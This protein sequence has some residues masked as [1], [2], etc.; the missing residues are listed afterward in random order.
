MDTLNL[1]ATEATD[2]RVKVPW[3]VA[4]YSYCWPPCALKCERCGAQHH[5]DFHQPGGLSVSV[6]AATAD[7]FVRLHR[8]CSKRT[9]HGK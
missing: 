2:Y 4:C 5:F 8:H 9:T 1:V 3:V 7:A 6:F